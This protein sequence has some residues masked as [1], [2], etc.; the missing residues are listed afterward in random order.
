MKEHII[1]G[2]YPLKKIKKQQPLK[3][4]IGLRGDKCINRTVIHKKN[5]TEELL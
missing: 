4:F 2:L 3:R 1:V 5:N